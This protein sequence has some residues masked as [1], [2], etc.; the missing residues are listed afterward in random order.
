MTIVGAVPFI[1]KSLESVIQS[2][3]KPTEKEEYDIDEIVNEDFKLPKINQ[4]YDPDSF[5]ETTIDEK[6]MIGTIDAYIAQQ[7]VA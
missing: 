5:K 3:F 2:P 4:N 1:R 6:T 7:K